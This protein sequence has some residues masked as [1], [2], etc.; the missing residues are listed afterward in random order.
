VPQQWV[1]VVPV[2]ELRLAKTRLT[3]FEPKMRAELALAVARDVVAAAIACP[4][5]VA[6]YV[7][8]NDLLAAETLAADGA[9]VIADTQDSG[10]NA[11]LSDGARVASGWYPR[12]GI[13]ALSSD[14]PAL[15]PTELTSAL[16]AAEGAPRCFVPDQAGTGTTL[17]TAAPGVPL[18][19][20]FGSA[21]RDRH[22][23][24]GAVELAGDWPG[25]RCDID[26]PADLERAILQQL[27]IHTAQS[28]R[29]LGPAG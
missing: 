11:A 14:L 25:L 9:F 29:R 28:L 5:V 21:S 13:A 10:L 8:T 16:T 20:D 27:G 22:L 12:A 6:V 19:P 18:A 24:S 4:T 2:K 17:L 23:R 3:H 15:S 26:T 1:V 7:I